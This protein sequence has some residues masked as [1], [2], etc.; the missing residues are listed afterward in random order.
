MYYNELGGITMFM[1]PGIYE[2]FTREEPF[3]DSYFAYLDEYDVLMTKYLTLY[4]ALEA[5][6]DEESF[7]ILE[8]MIECQGDME[9]FQAMHHF[10]QGALMGISAFKSEKTY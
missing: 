10:R 3:C 2:L 8:K 9:E 4:A 1:E 6:L 7:D 5:T